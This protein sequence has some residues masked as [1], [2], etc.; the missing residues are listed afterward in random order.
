MQMTD[1]EGNSIF[2]IERPDNIIL[3]DGCNMVIYTELIKCLSFR[4]GFIHSA[5]CDDCVKEY[6]SGFKIVEEHEFKWQ[7]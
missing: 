7:T 6:F 5:Q 3:C 4:K 1:L 2:S